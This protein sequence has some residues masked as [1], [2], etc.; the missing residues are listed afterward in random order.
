MTK[1]KTPRVRTEKQLA[2]DQRLREEAAKRRAKLDPAPVAFAEPTLQSPDDVEVQDKPD[3]ESLQR[4]IDSLMESNALLTASILRQNTQPTGLGV[5]RQNNLIGEVD[6]YLVDPDNY[7]D[8]T[9]RLAQEAR[10][11]TIAFN[12]NYELQ[13]AFSV[14]PYETKTGVNMREPE[15]TITLLRVVLDDQGERVKIIGRDGV[16]RDK[17]YIAR[18]LVFHEDPQ[19]ALVIARENNLAV[20]QEDEKTFLDEMRYLRIKEWLF[21]YLWPRPAQ[22]MEGITEESIGGTLVQVYLKSSEEPSSVDFDAIKS[23][24]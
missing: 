9:K 22:T 14:R 11:Q 21:G 5:G 6:K 7:P 24:V 1:R 10:L 17:F 15:F 4:Q 3:Y 18:R 12:H 19:A 8:P 20:D 13:Y 2:N 16:S 23:K